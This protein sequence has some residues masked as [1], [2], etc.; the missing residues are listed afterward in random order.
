MARLCEAQPGAKIGRLTVLRH[1]VVNR[2]GRNGNQWNE[3]V[4]ECRCE[5]GRETA[6][7]IYSLGTLTRSCGCLRPEVI[8]TH[9]L[10]K[11]N[12]RLY[13][14][15]YAMLNRCLNR[16]AKHWDSYGGRGINVCDEWAKSVEAFFA[17]A[18]ANGYADDLTIDRIDVNGNYEPSNCRWIPRRQQAENRRNT[19]RYTAWGE[20][21]TVHEWMRDPR[22]VL[23]DRRLLRSRIVIR[24]WEP[25]RA[26]TTPPLQ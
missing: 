21:K 12:R 25:E 15:W 23:K 2:V 26:M 11:L 10:R 14:T 1:T 22:C 13:Q 19:N 17:W 3:K 9:G 4:A 20:T 5:C 7:R 6:V 8:T 16:R 18:M 24:K